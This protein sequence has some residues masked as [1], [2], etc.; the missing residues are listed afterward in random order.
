LQS[1]RE[2]GPRISLIGVD[3]CRSGWVTATSN[4]SLAHLDFGLAVSF[5]EVLQGAEGRAM[6]VAVDIPIGLPDGGARACDLEAR[7]CLG[8]R[9]GSSVFPAPCRRALQGVG[10]YRLACALNIANGGK[11][12]SWQ[13]F[14][15]LRKIREVDDL[16]APPLQ[17]WVR[18]AHPEVT[19]AMLD[20]AGGP[21]HGKKSAVGE[22]ER[23]AILEQ[24]VPA[25]DLTAEHKRLGRGRVARDDLLDAA[26]CLVTTQR[27]MRSHAIVLPRGEPRIDGRGLRME[28]VA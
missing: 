15:I 18:E 27:V 6:L 13:V 19:F 16:M 1:V 11:G 17:A 7:A 22:L 26:A 23:L 3:G 10:D 8:R 20:P 2:K 14:N 25:F 12:I 5:A 24:F 9:R 4:E 21:V 28:I